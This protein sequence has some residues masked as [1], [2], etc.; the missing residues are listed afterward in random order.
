MLK[1]TTFEQS[2][3]A[4]KLM[5]MSEAQMRKLGEGKTRGLLELKPV[6]LPV[7]E[8]IVR[9]NHHFG[10]PIATK[11]G[12]ALVV[13]Y[14]RRC[15]HW[16]RPQWDED[17]SGCMMIRSLDGGR[18][19]SKPFDLRHYA[20]RDDGSLPFYS[21]GECLITASNGAVVLGHGAGTFRS[22]DRGETWEHFSHQF[23]R[24]LRPGETTTINCPRLIEHPQ[25]GLVRM[26]GTKLKTEDEGVHGWPTYSQNMHVAYSQDGG[27]TWQEEEHK[28]PFTATA[29][30]AMLFHEG[31]LVMVG[32][33]YD[34]INKT[35]YDP[36]T[37]TTSYLQHWSK[38]GWFPLQAKFTNM[39]TT[40]RERSGLPGKGSDTVDL[41]FNPVTKRF[42]VV[43]TDRMGGGVEGRYWEVPFTL[44]LWSI[45]PQ[46]LLAGSADWR[47]EGC[48]F[49]RQTP[50]PN[51]GKMS[52]GCHPAAAVIDEKEGVQHVFVYMGSPSG[53]AGV[54]HLK[55]TL[56][57][58]KLAAF[59]KE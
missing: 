6:V 5:N 13:N 15:S 11:A 29:E 34:T 47:F 54:F 51:R 58:P 59:L 40:D 32:R 12:D 8:L 49:E 57:T 37:L 45:D 50:M 25:Y 16:V 27:R 28:V 38:S 36:K 35:G 26:A 24:K 7:P 19:W 55:R 4:K 3:L 1:S 33:A 9:K 48:L 31:A 30:P 52:D 14:L 10:W 17:S 43:A 39:R 23:N 46:A 2:P 44:N 22:E 20:R 41:S 42:E 18:T 21:K 56:D 53:P